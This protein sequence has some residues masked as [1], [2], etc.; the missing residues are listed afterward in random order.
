MTQAAMQTD[1]VYIIGGPP[2]DVTRQMSDQPDVEEKG[3]DKEATGCCLWLPSSTSVLPSSL[4]TTPVYDEYGNKAFGMNMVSTALILFDYGSDISVAFWLRKEKDSDFF[5]ACTILLIVLPLIVVNLFSLVW[6]SQDH[7]VHPSGFVPRRR[8]LTTWPRRLLLLAHFIGLGPV[9]RQLQIMALGRREQKSEWRKQG[10]HAGPYCLTLDPTTPKANKEY[11]ELYMARKYYE[12]DA[13]Y[14]ALIDSF[15]QDAPQLILQLYILLARHP[16]DLLYWETAL[17]QLGS[18][19]LSLI[20][21]SGALVSYQQA[22]RWAD[23][24]RPQYTPIAVACQWLWRLLI[25]SGRMFVF[26]IF[27]T[28]HLKEFFIFASLHYLLM[29]TWLLLI[30]TNFCGSIDGVRRPIEELVYNLV[31]AAVLL[32]DIVNVTEGATRLKNMFFYIL[33]G[34]EQ[35]GL[36]AAWYLATNRESAELDGAHLR[37]WSHDPRWQT[38]VLALVPATYIGGLICLCTYYRVLHPGGR[39]PNPTHTATLL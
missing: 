31:I 29:I 1:G 18:V 23:A 26:C 27:L 3:E 28:V 30:R 21:L 37:P 6:Y 22:S 36:V 5:M 2:Q 14:L 20:S 4:T 13:A 35:A 39:M 19:L 34:L 10:R 33:F 9:V 12:R 15:I 16:K 25:L 38:A 32:F 8:H 11:M 24:A 7:L 17:S